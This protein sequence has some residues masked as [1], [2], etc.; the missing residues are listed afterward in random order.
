MHTLIL[1]IKTRRRNS[2]Y[3]PYNWRIVV[4]ALNNYNPKVKVTKVIWK[5]PDTGQIKVNIDGASKGNPGRSSWGFCVTDG[6]G[7]I[8]HAQAQDINDLACTNIQAEAMAILHALNFIKTAQMDRVMIEI[9][10]LLM[11]NIVEKSQKVPWRVA[12]ILEEIWRLMHGRTMIIKHILR[13]EINW[14]IIWPIQPWK[15]ETFV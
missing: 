1:L 5:P 13:E 6:K 12:T 8:G 3:V 4:D 9:D 10:S 2:K 11:K 15:K 7:D 14:Q